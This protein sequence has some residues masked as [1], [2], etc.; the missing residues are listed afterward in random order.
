MDLVDT[1]LIKDDQKKENKSDLDRPEIDIDKA[2]LSENQR[3]IGENG[4]LD[5]PFSTNGNSSHTQQPTKDCFKAPYDGL[6]V[7][8]EVYWTEYY[9]NTEHT[10]EWNN[11]ILEAKPMAILLQVKMYIWFLNL[12]Q[13]FLYT[14]PMA[15]M[16]FLETGFEFSLPQKKQVRI[17]DLAIVLNSNPIPLGDRDNSY[18]GIFDICIESVSTSSR[19]EI[20]RDTIIKR[21]QLS[22]EANMPKPVCKNIISWM[23]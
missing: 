22:N 23:N 6:A 3:I 18:A 5:G 14:N 20:E 8:L 19:K 4:R 16:T 21:G 15:E 1:M 2:A 12:L 7:P 11:G 13:D 10:Y 9:D 17:P